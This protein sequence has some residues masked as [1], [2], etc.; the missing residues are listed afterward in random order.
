MTRYH[1]AALS[2]L[3]GLMAGL[4]TIS[5]GQYVADWLDGPGPRTVHLDTVSR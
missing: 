5:A 1:R 2:L 4:L 3:G